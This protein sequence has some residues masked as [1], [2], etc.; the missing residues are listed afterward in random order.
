MSRRMSLPL[1]RLHRFHPAIY[2]VPVFVAALTIYYLSQSP[3]KREIPSTQGSGLHRSNAQRRRRSRANSP[4]PSR[5][6]L[7]FLDDH[8]SDVEVLGYHTL[9]WSNG[10]DLNTPLCRSA[11]SVF[12]SALDVSTS[13]EV[14]ACRSQI[15]DA[16]LSLYLFRHLDHRALDHL[17]Q[18]QVVTS[19]EVNGFTADRIRHFLVLN[20][21][22]ELK[23]YICD[24]I[25]NQ[26]SLGRDLEGIVSDGAFRASFRRSRHDSQDNAVTEIDS[27]SDASWR[28]AENPNEDQQESRNLL[29]LLYAMA[30]DKNR[31][32]GFV[33]RGITC[34]WYRLFPHNLS[35]I[36]HAYFMAGLFGVYHLVQSLVSSSTR[37]CY[38]MD[39]SPRS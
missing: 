34:N 24:W 17:Q 4:E 6:E 39:W 31:R 37:I 9:R 26:L 28:A 14:R 16:C 30:H 15:Q 33:H 23:D 2:A 13:A 7:G 29:A 36:S 3:E 5:I 25:S 8:T 11:L 20:Q 38:C 1:V 35:L 22:G 21:C 10:E 32:E 12:D 27:A 19:L 18:E